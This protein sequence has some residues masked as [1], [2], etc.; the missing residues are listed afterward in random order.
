MGYAIFKEFPLSTS[1]YTLSNIKIYPNPVSDQL[2][3]SSENT[4]IERIV[5]YSIYGKMVLET[6]NENNSIDASTLSKGIY[7]IEMSSE[8]VKTVKK[9]IKN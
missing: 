7:F 6:A 4:V 3:I 8:T 2:F 5:V 9:F 1:D